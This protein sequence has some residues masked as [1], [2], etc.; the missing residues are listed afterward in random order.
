M[1]ALFCRYFSL[2]SFIKRQVECVCVR[3]LCGCV[4]AR[5]NAECVECVECQLQG[6][7]YLTFRPLIKAKGSPKHITSCDRYDLVSQLFF[8]SLLH[9]FFI[10]VDHSLP[11]STHPF[12]LSS[13]LPPFSVVTHSPHLH[14][15]AHR[16]SIF[17]LLK[18]EV[19]T[20]LSVLTSQPCPTA[21]E[22][23]T[24]TTTLP[25]ATT[26]PP[27]ATTTQSRLHPPLASIPSDTPPQTTPHLRQLLLQQTTTHHQQQRG[28]S[29]PTTVLLHEAT[30]AVSTQPTTSTLR[31]SPRILTPTG[32]FNNSAH[33]LPQPL[34][35]VQQ[36][37]RE[38]LS[39]RLPSTSTTATLTTLTTLTS[40]LRQQQRRIRL[41][42]TSVE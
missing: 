30:P 1:V 11:S 13:S 5:L 31:P 23:F 20:L 12:S 22:N 39:T 16:P 41:E 17:L 3:V 19:T 10:A 35:V 25:V 6:D 24:S 15:Y 32:S 28:V 2:C 18:R 8:F 7:P 14:P 36:P 4:C 40:R 33:L 9:T 34:L 38:C 37:L 29:T 21:Y 26:P 27:P 42:D